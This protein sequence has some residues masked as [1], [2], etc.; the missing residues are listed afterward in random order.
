MGTPHHLPHYFPHLIVT[1]KLTLLVVL[2]ARTLSPSF[3]HMPTP[4]GAPL[5]RRKCQ[6]ASGLAPLGPLPLKPV[7]DG[8]QLPQ[9]HLLQ[10]RCV[11]AGPLGNLPHLPLLRRH[12]AGRPHDNLP[13]RGA[14]F[15]CGSIPRAVSV[16]GATHTNNYL[17]IYC[18]AL[19]CVVQ[20]PIAL[21]GILHIPY[22]LITLK[23]K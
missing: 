19:C 18:C 12:E 4:A 22:T 8:I 5:L 21:F 1:N 3:R 20:Y 7:N 15:T 9:G 23:V 14:T 10:E 16:A 2:V 17:I 6:L 11:R 13:W